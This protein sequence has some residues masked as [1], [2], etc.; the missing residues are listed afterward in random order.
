M[1][2]QPVAPLTDPA[3]EIRAEWLLRER[4]RQIAARTDRIF[5]VLM[6]LQ[7]AGLVLW[8]LLATP[9]TW[10]GATSAVHPHVW[11][12]LLMGGATASLPV[13]LA[14]TIPGAVLTRH[15]IALAQVILSSLLIHISGGRI[16]THFH[17]FG[18]L[19]F[20]A[21]YRDWRVLIPPTLFV[22]ADHLIRGVWW[23]DSVFGIAVSDH[24]RWVEHAA[25]VLFEDAFLLVII[26]QSRVEMFEVAM[27][28]AELERSHAEIRD[29]A[30]R[31]ENEHRTK[32]LIIEG[33][34]DAV[35]QMDQAGKIIGWNGQA[36]RTFGWSA[37]EAIGAPLAGLMIPQRYR[38][39]HTAGVE[40]FARTGTGGAINRRLE[41]EGLRKTGEVFPLEL[42][43]TPIGRSGEATFCAFVRDITDRRQA[44]DELRRA[45]DHAEAASAA[46]SQFLANVSHEIRTPLNG[47]LGF[48]DLLLRKSGPAREA[49]QQEYLGTI[50]DCSEHLLALINDILDLSKIESGR[51]ELHPV[52]C[53]PHAVIAAVVSVLRVKAR[54]KGIA[55]D[56]RWEGAIPEAIVTDPG[57]LRQL[58]I[59]LV[60]NAVKFTLEG[61]V[62]IEARYSSV[63]VPSRLT[64]TIR[65]SGVGIPPDKLE[66]IFDPFVQVDNS[67]TRHF[68][69]TGL[70]LPIA[71]RIARGLRGD[72]TVAS[73]VGV[74][75]IFSVTV[76]APLADGSGWHDGISSD[77]VATT[78]DGSAENAPDLRG[79][80][81]LV[82]EDGETNRELLREFLGEA[83]VIVETAE[84]GALGVDRASRQSFDAILMDMQM[85][86]MDGYT[87]TRRLRQRGIHTPIIALT[88]H[89]MQGDA[90]KCLDAGCSDYLSKPIR[91]EELIRKLQSV[92]PQP[93]APGT[94]TSKVVRNELAR[95]EP[96]RSTLP[97]HNPRFQAIVARF[98]ERLD[99]RLIE[100][101]QALVERQ[102]Q[103]IT[104]LAHWLKGTGG[105]AGFEEFTE[106]AMELEARARQEQGPEIAQI[107]GQLHELRSLIEEVVPASRVESEPAK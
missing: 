55:L 107:L 77:M 101:D 16:E 43:I 23:P 25:W 46:K 7:W 93:T 35:V 53:S 20:L 31:L 88:A 3:T 58:L 24:W 32:T 9:R 97:V 34:L 84:D 79:K 65:D 63:E 81:V 29:Q 27:R 69:G 52:R 42:A 91:A 86:V 90:D 73:T 26:R 4:E 59:N 98:V 44:E 102:F 37:A 82:V 106:P 60:G 13:L 18:S 33:A 11:M 14:G 94:E 45:R 17:I 12:A 50:K 56:Y 51:V 49:V 103:R 8:A 64:F 104:E 78:D 89:A 38:A 62:W 76:E 28:T 75:S 57:R 48:I 6:L 36:E 87:A 30:E 21:A 22:A 95:R 19:A 39:A 47:I 80:N 15:V 40:A 71:R 67:L 54:E 1:K 85:P 83:G 96:L 68:E 5:A 100:L 105:T 92:L 74:G 41:L 61:G 10:S 72:V 99:E 70:G 2:D 66:A